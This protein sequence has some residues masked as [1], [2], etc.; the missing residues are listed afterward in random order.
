MS[1][2][3]EIKQEILDCINTETGEI[4]DADKLEQLQM[5]KH[6][7]LRNIAFVAINASADIAAYKEQEKRFKA[8]RTSAE[9]TLAW[10]KET[11]A[12]ELAGQKMKEAEFTIS[13]RPSEA[14]EIDEGADIPPE[15]VN[16]NPV[17]DKMS[18]KAALKEGAVIS[19]CRLVQKQNIQIK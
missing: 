1:T 7:K 12:R 16:M 14:I 18:L 2:L 5:D 6:E 19:G 10:A 8:K 3:Y 13:Y 15:F 11:L 17:I 9:K 4:L